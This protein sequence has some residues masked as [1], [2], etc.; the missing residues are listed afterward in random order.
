[1]SSNRHFGEKN[2]K[3]KQP[4]SVWKPKNQSIFD[5]YYF[6]LLMSDSIMKTKTNFIHSKE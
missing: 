2:Q 3:L 1:M 6:T 5:N 4:N